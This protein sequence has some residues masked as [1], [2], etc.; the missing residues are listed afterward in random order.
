MHVA[1]RAVSDALEDLQM[2]PPPRVPRH[3]HTCAPHLPQGRERLELLDERL[4]RQVLCIDAAPVDGRAVENGVGD[5]VELR[6]R[7]HTFSS[8]R[9]MMALR[10]SGVHL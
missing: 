2:A 1:E 6:L 7:V 8:T 10:S 5:S 4:V 3:R 9:L